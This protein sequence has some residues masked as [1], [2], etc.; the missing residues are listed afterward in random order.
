MKRIAVVLPEPVAER[1][2]LRAYRCGKSKSR[3]VRDL[4]EKALAE[5]DLLTLGGPADYKNPNRSGR[6]ILK[7]I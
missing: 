3:F 7:G 1:L 5:G 4:I 6:R 2:S